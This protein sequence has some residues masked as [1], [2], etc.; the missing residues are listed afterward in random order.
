MSTDAFHAP[1]IQICF[2]SKAMGRVYKPFCD[3]WLQS[4]DPMPD[5]LLSYP[6]ILFLS[7]NFAYIAYSRSADDTPTSAS[8]LS[9]FYPDDPTCFPYA[10]RRRWS[11]FPSSFPHAATSLKLNGPLTSPIIDLALHFFFSTFFTIPPQLHLPYLSSPR[12]PCSN[13]WSRTKTCH[14]GNCPNNL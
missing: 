10:L 2:N 8:A 9:A 14:K 13:N 6:P 4:L 1:D 3:Y 11:Q 7:Q 12:R 5:A